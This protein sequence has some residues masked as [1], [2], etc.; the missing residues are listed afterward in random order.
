MGDIVHAL[1]LAENAR[2]AGAEVGWVVGARVRWAPRRQPR[3]LPVFLGRH[4][5]VA[6]EP[7][8]FEEPR[9]DFRACA[10]DCATLRPTPRSTCR[11]CG[12]PRLLARLARAP[13]VSLGA[14]DRRERTSA[15]PRGSSRPSRP[16]E[17]STSWTRTF[18]FSTPLSESPS[19]RPLPTPGTSWTS[20]A[21]TADRFAAGSPAAFRA[22]PSRGEP[23]ARRR[24]ARK[25][26]R[27]SPGGSSREP[28]CRPAISWGPGD[29]TRVERLARLL[30]EAAAPSASRRRR[31][32]ARHR[33][34]RALFVGGDTGPVHLAD[35]LGVPTLA[36]F[37]PGARRNVPGRNRPY[38][39]A[40]L[41]YDPGTDLETVVTKAIE[42]ARCPAAS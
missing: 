16:R 20:R 36:L 41:R 15:R 3:D 29:E 27:R 5:A 1:P 38:R 31:A 8:L 32:R 21:R 13:V 6:P 12:S 10:P 28:A 24:G 14:R 2:R 23:R 40:W 42:A 9:R 22:P 37:Q 26:M 17:R 30:P 18:R 11:V 7:I 35:A 34:A 19:R 4:R 33:R 39:G 25:G